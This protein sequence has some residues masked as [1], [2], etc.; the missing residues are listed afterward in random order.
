MIK[1][2][3]L[4]ALLSSGVFVSAAAP[5]SPSR[6]LDEFGDIKCEDE[7]AR[8][9]NL[10]VQLQNEPRSRAAIIFFAGKMA[11]DKLPKRGE[12]E[13]R[14]ERI[15]EYLTKRRGIPAANLVL[16]NGGYDNNYRVQLWVISPEAG[17]PKPEPSSSVKD[18]RYRSGK[19]NPRNYRCGI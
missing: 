6:K 4:V 18:V 15:K 14:V 3:I 19:V 12:A 11:G 5:D 7:M 17:L 1:S 10:A 16:M 13:A 8:L 9:D 2:I